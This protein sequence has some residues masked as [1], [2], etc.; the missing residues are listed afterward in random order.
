MPQT[1][2]PL[3]GEGQNRISD[4]VWYEKREGQIFYFH[5]GLPI[6][7]H[8]SSDE[9]SF[10]MITSQLVVAG[11]CTQSEVVEAF[12]ISKISMKRYTKKFREDGP[13]GFYSARA[14]RGAGV[15]T[16]EVLA[17]AQEL[18]LSGLS[19]PQTARELGLK[20]DTV[21]KAIAAG[22]LVK[23]EKKERA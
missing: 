18:L 11:N 14:T 7:T 12:G 5:G 13:G 16:A 9:A 10:R 21:R 17:Q 4:V 23:G 8:S 19:A 22:R 2:L 15:L 20:P 3:Y 1:L 6:F